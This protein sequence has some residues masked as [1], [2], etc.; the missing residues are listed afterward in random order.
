MPNDVAYRQ[1][2]PTVQW[3]HSCS[4]GESSQSL[5]EVM[6]LYSNKAEVV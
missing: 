2:L 5:L 3:Y 1:Q 6:H 4:D